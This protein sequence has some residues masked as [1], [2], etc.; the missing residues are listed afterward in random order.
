MC[1][2]L[3]VCTKSRNCSLGKAADQPG[4]GTACVLLAQVAGVPWGGRE[5]RAPCLFSG[6]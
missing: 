6:L 3:S 5:R 2:S 1:V 4:V